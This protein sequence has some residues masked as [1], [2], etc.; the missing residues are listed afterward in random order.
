MPTV[1]PTK[2]P[3]EYPSVL[4]RITGTRADLQPFAAAIPA[5][6]DGPP[7][8]AL[9]ASRISLRLKRNSFPKPRMRARCVESAIAEKPN[10]AGAF[11]RTSGTFAQVPIVA[12]K[13][14]GWGWGAGLWLDVR[15]QRAD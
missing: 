5:T 6:V 9:L 4:V 15:D 10:S 2:V 13:T 3:S 14:C 12:K 11:A 8:F 7:I 1:S